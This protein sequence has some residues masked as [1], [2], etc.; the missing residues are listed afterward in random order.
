MPKIA[1]IKV[2][3]SEDVVALFEEICKNVI[4]Q[5]TFEVKKGLLQ[6]KGKDKEVADKKPTW[7]DIFVL[8]AKI[9]LGFELVFRYAISE[10]NDS[11][12]PP[13][14]MEKASVVKE[15]EMQA[16]EIPADFLSDMVKAPA[17]EQVKKE[18]DPNDPFA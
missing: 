18:V 17:I 13:P 3:S 5:T 16:S 9:D 4:G 12:V 2:K 6:W 11:V 7:N 8:A 15:M 14:E 1:Y 10:P